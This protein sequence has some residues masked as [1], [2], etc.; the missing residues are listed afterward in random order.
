MLKV[1]TGDWLPFTAAPARER[2]LSPVHYTHLH[3][4]DNNGNLLNAVNVLFGK[5]PTKYHIQ[6]KVRLARFEGTDMMEFRDQTVCY[7]IIMAV[8]GILPSISC[9]FLVICLVMQ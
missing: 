6:C 3:L 9:R 2:S 7:G 1:N 4:S 8:I 5:D